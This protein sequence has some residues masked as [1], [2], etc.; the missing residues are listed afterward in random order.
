L[1]TTKPPKKR[2][3]STIEFQL[4]YKSGRPVALSLFE[5]LS[6]LACGWQLSYGFFKTLP[7]TTNLSCYALRCKGYRQLRTLSFNSS[8]EDLYKN[9]IET[10][11]KFIH[12]LKIL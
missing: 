7:W 3:G 9:G 11:L 2:E 4:T 12:H 8:I 6:I 5:P 10:M 1:D